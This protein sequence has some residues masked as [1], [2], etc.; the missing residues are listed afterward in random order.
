MD[1]IVITMKTPSL[2]ILNFRINLTFIKLLLVSEVTVA[3][4]LYKN[5]SRSIPK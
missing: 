3:Q 4:N 5:H 1:L 2:S